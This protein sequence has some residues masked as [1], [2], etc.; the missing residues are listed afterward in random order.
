MEGK[1]PV[2]KKTKKK[3]WKV[4]GRTF[5][6]RDSKQKFRVLVTVIAKLP[7]CVRGDTRLCLQAHSSF[8]L[9][10][11]N[12]FSSKDSDG[13]WN[14]L[15][16]LVVLL[17]LENLAPL[18]IFPRWDVQGQTSLEEHQT[19]ITFNVVQGGFR[20]KQQRF[21]RWRLWTLPEGYLRLQRS[22]KEPKKKYLERAGRTWRVIGRTIC[23]IQAAFCAVRH[24]QPAKR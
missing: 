3:T 12:S 9:K 16:R 14:S 15:P 21:W 24:H 4:L 1:K 13:S 7:I 5:R 8:L 18:H 20:F 6:V 11:T 17:S 22:A 19:A 10:S 23:H 2:P